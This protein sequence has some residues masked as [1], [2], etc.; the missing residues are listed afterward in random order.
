MRPAGACLT[1]ALSLAAA[2]DLAAETVSLAGG[3]LRFGGEASFSLSPK[4]TGHFND[5]G[6]QD[7][8][9]R[10]AR[11]GL[12]A[13]VRVGD[14]VELLGELRTDNFNAPKLYALY[15]RVHP[16]SGRAVDVQ[17]GLIP[18]VFGSFARRAYAYDNP[19]IGYPLAY[20]YATTL[21]PD[22]VPATV[23]DILWARGYGAL[24]WYPVGSPAYAPGLPLVDGVRWDAGIQVRA[25]SQPFQVTAAL[26]QGTLSYPRVHD[27]NDGKQVSLRC[28]W[29]PSAAVRLGVSAARG[30][31]LDREVLAQLPPELAAKGYYQR[32]LGADGE[33]AQDHW[34]VRVEGVWSTWDAALTQP[35]PGGLTLRAASLAAEGR[36]KLAAGVHLA[37]RVDHL[38]FNEVQGSRVR[39]TWDAPVTRV[40][41]GVG[42]MAA[43]HVLLKGVYQH[44]WRDGGRVHSESLAAVQALLWF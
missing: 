44:N 33:W 4:D 31:Y 21:R 25:G 27:N 22:A 8:I 18:P 5:T 17:A 23:D 6:Y 35:P 12:S 34:L 37:A 24:V 19:V 39:T 36:Y 41:A 3:R 28:I 11:L 1:L 26:T 20:H 13:S 7:D 30:Q 16:W 2:A 9:L 15:A 42:W 40:E 43:R 29:Q 38:G 32:A 14:K 10:M